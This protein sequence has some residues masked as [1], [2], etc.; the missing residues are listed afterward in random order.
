MLQRFAIHLA[1]VLLFAF[2]QIGVATHEISHVL[3]AEKH[4]QQDKNTTAEQC[5]QCLGYAK[6]A[7]GL[8]LSAFVIPAIT[9]DFKTASSHYFS[10]QSYPATAYVARAPPQITSI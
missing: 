4:S 9:S 1:L 3:G 8:A 10:F 7:S 6:V 5:E 2:T